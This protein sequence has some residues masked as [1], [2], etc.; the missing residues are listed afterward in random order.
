LKF[1]GDPVSATPVLP[2]GM[3]DGLDVAPSAMFV[4]LLQSDFAV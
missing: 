1:L 3:L 2:F 4:M